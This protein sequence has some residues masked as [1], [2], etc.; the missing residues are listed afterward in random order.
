MK[1]RYPAV[2]GTFYPAEA[3]LL[4]SAIK[5]A[6]EGIEHYGDSYLAHVQGIGGIVPHAGYVYCGDVAVSFFKL[7]R[8]LGGEYDTFIIL[9]P[10]HYGLGSGFYTE[11][12]GAW[13]TP[14]GKLMV[15]RQLADEMDLQVLHRSESSEHAAE[16]VLPYLQYYMSYDF[17]ILPIGMHKQDKKSAQKL[18]ALIRRG[19]KV[20][21]KRIALIASSDFSHYVPPDVGFE[22]DNL[23]LRSIVDLDAG[24]LYQTVIDN[25]ISVCGY[26]PIMALLL[27][28]RSI[29]DKPKVK[30][31]SRGNSGK[32]GT[33]N[34]VVDY[35]S[36][37]VYG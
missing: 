28:A 30:V 3:R 7:L 37:L 21:K 9:Y 5:K 12:H 2:A 32:T 4:K 6:E 26:G 19:Q 22:M 20:L 36:A 11:A 25:D 35:V 14:L 16:V 13:E 8:K 15:D 29:A 24:G 27:Y 1:I 34:L 33:R 18:A 31:L 10:D 23:V 17:K